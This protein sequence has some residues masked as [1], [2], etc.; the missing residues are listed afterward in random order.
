[1]KEKC[2]FCRFF[3]NFY[4]F[5]AFSALAKREKAG[6][7]PDDF[8]RFCQRVGVLLVSGF[9]GAKFAVPIDRS[10][11]KVAEHIEDFVASA[12]VFKAETVFN[13]AVRAVNE[14]VARADST[15]NS[16]FAEV[17]RFFDGQKGARGSDFA[18][19]RLG[20]ELKARHLIGNRT[21]N[22]VNQSIFVT[23]RPEIIRVFFGGIA[24]IVRIRVFLRVVELRRARKNVD[25]RGIVAETTGKNDFK[26]SAFAGLLDGARFEER[27][28]KRGSGTVEAGRFGRVDQNVAVVDSGAAKGRENVFDHIDLRVADGETRLARFPDSVGDEGR[29]R[30]GVREVDAEKADAGIVVGGKEGKDDVATCPKA[31]TGDVDATRQRSLAAGRL[32]ADDL[33]KGKAQGKAPAA[34]RSIERSCEG[35]EKG[36]RGREE[37]DSNG[38]KLG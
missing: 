9:A 37:N 22:V 14:N 6:I 12:L 34:V 17:S 8:E 38:V 7:L 3:L 5:T 31:E 1:M 10:K 25:I 36:K 23:G 28:Q 21:R 13:R 30:R 33:G 29:N 4:V 18:A 19:K 15:A 11:R 35:A 32:D 27:F 24:R 2:G 26:S 20:R 16:L